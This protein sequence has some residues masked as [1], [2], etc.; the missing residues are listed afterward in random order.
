MNEPRNTGLMRQRTA[1]NT[2]ARAGLR[3]S[4][5]ENELALSGI[6]G[7]EIIAFLIDTHPRLLSC[8]RIVQLHQDCAHLEMCWPS[9]RGRIGSLKI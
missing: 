9:R 1:N 8:T 6:E 5:T 2:R 7:S 3:A 4:I